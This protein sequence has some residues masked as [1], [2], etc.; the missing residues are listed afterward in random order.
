M[1]RARL[2]EVPQSKDFLTS[3]PPITLRDLPQSTKDGPGRARGSGDV[4]QRAGL[5]AEAPEGRV[6][7]DRARSQPPTPC[8]R[9]ESDRM[10]EA[11]IAHAK[12]MPTYDPADAMGDEMPA[13]A[14][15]VTRSANVNMSFTRPM[16]AFVMR[17]RVRACLVPRPARRRRRSRRPMSCRAHLSS[18]PFGS[19]PPQAYSAPPPIGCDASAGL[20]LAARRGAGRDGARDVAAAGAVVRSC[21]RARFPSGPGPMLS[22]IVKPREP[23]RAHRRA[24]RARAPRDRRR[25]P[26]GARCARRAREAAAAAAV[27]AAKTASPATEASAAATATGP[28][29]AS[30]A[31][32]SASAP[33]GVDADP[34][35]ARCR[36]G[37]IERGAR[38]GS[39]HGA[40]PPKRPRP[41]KKKPVVVKPVEPAT[42]PTTTAAA[43]ATSESAPPPRAR[44]RRRRRPRRTPTPS[45]PRPRRSAVTTRVLAARTT[46][47]SSP[48]EEA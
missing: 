14:P 7:V 46:G 29:P 39:A 48:L 43:P 32:A 15:T 19:A 37:H 12:A 21:P 3:A 35:P 24:A 44:R 31:V 17:C 13:S 4:D 45:P 33:G 10:D 28:Q 23:A 20:P 34:K 8:A 47:A 16:A 25:R 36:A 30:S 42:E 11:D 2:D 6:A 27:A 1:R 38:V 5:L 41:K 40:M 26:R 22:Q 18:A 9:V